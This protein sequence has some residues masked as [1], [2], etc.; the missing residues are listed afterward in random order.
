MVMLQS[1]MVLLDQL[2]YEP[3]IL[4]LNVPKLFLEIKI[5]KN[6]LKAHPYSLRIIRITKAS[7]FFHHHF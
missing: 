2:Y 3:L 6:N 1:P 7:I 5:T 4:F